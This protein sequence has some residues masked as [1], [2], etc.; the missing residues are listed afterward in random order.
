M[1][2]VVNHRKHP[3]SPAPAGGFTIIEVLIVLAIAGLILLLV[4]QT[5][6]TLQRSSRNSQRNEDV[7]AILQAVS[8]YELNNSAKFPSSC[9]STELNCSTTLTLHQYNA[10]TDIQFFPMDIAGQ[11]P[12]PSATIGSV[13]LHHFYQCSGGSATSVGAGSRDIVALYAVETGSGGATPQ[14]QQL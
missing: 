7:A 12:P 10:S 3:I 1:F 6:P 8:H 14:C 4:F 2:R 11:I 13:Q 9:A 5:I